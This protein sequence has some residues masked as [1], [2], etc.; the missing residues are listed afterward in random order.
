MRTNRRRQTVDAAD[1]CPAGEVSSWPHR[2]LR[3]G[4][5]FQITLPLR[6]CRRLYRRDDALVLISS[7]TGVTPTVGILEYLAAQPHSGAP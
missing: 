3:P 7:G 5:P 6:R 1:G 2:H 4:D